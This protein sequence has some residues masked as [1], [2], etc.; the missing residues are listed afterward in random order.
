MPIPQKG[1]NRGGRSYSMGS[2]ESFA[3]E[4]IKLCAEVSKLEGPDKKVW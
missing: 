2:C 3:K 4:F 1:F